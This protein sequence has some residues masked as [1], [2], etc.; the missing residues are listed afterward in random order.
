MKAEEDLEEHKEDIWLKFLVLLY[1]LNSIQITHYFKYEPRFDGAFSRNNLARIKDGACVVN[2]NDKNSYGTH[3]VSLF[4][5]KHLAVYF[6]Y[7]FFWN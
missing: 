6:L 7:T 1:P 2:L 5:Y 4:I 3:W